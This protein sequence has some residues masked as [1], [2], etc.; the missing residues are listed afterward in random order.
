MIL[1]TT[2]KAKKVKIYVKVLRRK[3]QMPNG[4][5]ES[6]ALPKGQVLIKDSGRRRTIVYGEI[7]HLDNYAY[8]YGRDGGTKYINTV[9]AF[10][11][12]HMLK[13]YITNRDTIQWK[14]YIQ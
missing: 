13:D 11:M 7:E 10:V 12:Q 5:W 2:I 9:V 1:S 14:E 4:Q 3:I 8:V 6:I